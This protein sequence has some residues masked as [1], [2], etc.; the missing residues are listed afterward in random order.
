M[1]LKT[2][3]KSTLNRIAIPNLTLGLII[4]QLLV[5]VISQISQE[6]IG[7]NQEGAMLA[8]QRLA[9][10]PA[11]VWQGEIWRVLTFL[12]LPPNAHPLLLFFAWYIFYMMGQALEHEWGTP[13]YT[14]YLLLGYIATVGLAFTNP[15]QPVGNA[16][17]ASS[18]FLAFAALYPNF[19]IMLF[20][21][22]PIKIKWLAYLT[23]GGFGLTLANGSNAERLAIL[24]VTFN[25]LVFFGLGALATA[26]TRRWQ[27]SRK[28]EQVV[29]SLKPRHICASC[30][31]N[32]KSQPTLEFR[33]CSKCSRDPATNALRCYCLEHLSSHEHV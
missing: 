13:C 16:Y 14:Q 1:S 22:L 2:T 15:W 9:L 18:V 8:T 12:L 26:R 30:G 21:I 10:I 11:L 7:L 29:E 28:M 25:F 5:F 19:T 20:F 17:L 33:Y 23:W 4:G 31:A 27:L 6:G 3:L 32:D 24:A